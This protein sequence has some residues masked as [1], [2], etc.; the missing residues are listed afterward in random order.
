M[1]QVVLFTDRWIHYNDAILHTHSSIFSSALPGEA[2]CFSIAN[3]CY[4]S[5]LL[6]GSICKTFTVL[7]C[8]LNQKTYKAQDGP[9]GFQIRYCSSSFLNTPSGIYQVF[10]QVLEVIQTKET[11]VIACLHLYMLL[12]MSISKYHLAFQKAVLSYKVAEDVKLVMNI[13]IRNAFLSRIL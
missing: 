1:V 11:C 4:Y 12:L 3:V 7:V 2:S 6:E 5:F 8:R 10:K 13:G 9:S